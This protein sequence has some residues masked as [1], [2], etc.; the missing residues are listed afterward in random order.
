MVEVQPPAVT[1]EV[2]LYARVSGSDQREDPERQPGRPAAFAASEGLTVTQTVSEVGSALNG[3]RPH[4]R[5]LLAH[6]RDR[7]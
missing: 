2:A 3:A 4:L 5:R 7:V 1:G 6:R